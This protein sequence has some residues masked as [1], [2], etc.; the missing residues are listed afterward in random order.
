M[1]GTFYPAN[2]SIRLSENNGPLPIERAVSNNQ[3]K[4]REKIFKKKKNCITKRKIHKNTAREKW[5]WAEKERGLC[6][7]VNEL[8]ALLFISVCVCVYKAG[9]V[10][11]T[12]NNKVILIWWPV[13][14]TERREREGKRIKEWESNN[15][16]QTA[17]AE[18]RPVIGAVKCDSST[19]S[20]TWHTH[21]HR[22]INHLYHSPSFFLC[23]HLY[24][25]LFSK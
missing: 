14:E 8:H 1:K 22:K 10:Y 21:T 19:A 18:Q 16:N 2:K 3:K 7:C 25:P 11:I 5:T 23:C 13:G 4:S 15:T 17:L 12:L 9:Q 24:Y 20:E 6:K